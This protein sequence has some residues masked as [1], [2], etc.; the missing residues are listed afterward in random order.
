[1]TFDAGPVTVT[2]TRSATEPASGTSNRIPRQPANTN[3]DG[4]VTMDIS[5]P[6]FESCTTN[7]PG[8]K[9]KVTTNADRGPWKVALQ[10]GTPSTARLII[11]AGGFV[12]ETSG[13]L[14]CTVTAAPGKAAEAEAAW[15][16]GAP[17][18]LRLSGATVP[19]KTEGGYFCPTS[20]T[21][22]AITAAYQITNT[23]D[24][25]HQITVSPASR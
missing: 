24:P 8:L 4:S 9:A 15:T 1:M 11:P 19:V 17:S 12:L 10:H 21:T 23:T 2:C 14:S 16:N 13:L 20:I 6:V 7:A 5:A 18:T 22:A 3:A 25:A